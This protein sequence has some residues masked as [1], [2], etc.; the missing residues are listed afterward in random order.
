MSP[1]SEVR[2]REIGAALIV[3]LLSEWKVGVKEIIFL[4]PSYLCAGSRP[5]HPE[6]SEGP[7][8]VAEKN[9]Q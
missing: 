4:Q 8:L 1:R 5:C 2:S 3:V 7:E 9:M 6:R